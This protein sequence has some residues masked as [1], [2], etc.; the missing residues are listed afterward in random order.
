MGGIAAPSFLIQPSPA[1]ADPG[2]LDE[3]TLKILDKNIGRATVAKLS[4][5][6]AEGAH[7]RIPMMEA[8][9]EAKDYP[10]L[11]RI[12]HEIAGESLSIGAKQ[13]AKL[14]RQMEANAI[15]KREATFGFIQPI[16][17]AMNTAAT[18]LMLRYR[19][20]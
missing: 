2:P 19:E 16:A 20:L 14:A 5:L 18:A 17:E 6:F 9:E 3:M 10:A 1:D 8:A 7:N 11:H 15:E 4:S 12:A 13:V